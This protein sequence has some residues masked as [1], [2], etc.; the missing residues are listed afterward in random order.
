MQGSTN[1]ELEAQ[2]AEEIV[3]AATDRRREIPE[4]LESESGPKTIFE[5]VQTTPDVGATV[6]AEARDLFAQR[7]FTESARVL[8]SAERLRPDDPEVLS[9]SAIVNANSGKNRQKV[10]GALQ[11][12]SE[13]FGAKAIT[14][15]TVSDVA[16]ARFQFD[17]AQKAARTAVQ[18]APRSVDAWHSLAASYVGHGWYDEAAECLARVDQIDP[19]RRYRANDPT[20]LTFG[21]WQIG[22]SINYW[23]ITRTYIAL[24]SVVAF[25]YIGLLGLALALSAPMLLREVRVRRLPE[26]FRSLADKAWRDEH[27]LRIL[28]A[29]A[30]MG[31]LILWVLL[32]S[33]RG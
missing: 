27:K 11:R 9:L 21:Q 22:R 3:A 7:R 31:V 2:T 26:P 29:V 24:A 33:I 25:V 19:E 16:L 23:A 20:A 28:N 17:P 12:L 15:R 32:F 10:R 8:E 6:L 14:W 13:D 30:V 5:T 1:T 18:M 4:Q